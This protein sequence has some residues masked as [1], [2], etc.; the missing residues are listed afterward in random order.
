[1]HVFAKTLHVNERMHLS[2]LEGDDRKPKRSLQLHGAWGCVG[3]RVCG[4]ENISKSLRNGDA[5]TFS[6]RRTGEV[7]FVAFF[8]FFLIRPYS[9]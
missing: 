3:V 1:M 2:T 7:L 8:L 5:R 6:A 4:S 9:A